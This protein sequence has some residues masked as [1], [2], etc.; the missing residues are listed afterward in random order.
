MHCTSCAV[1]VS[2]PD[3]TNSHHPGLGSR[4]QASWMRR[5][6][7]FCLPRHADFA[8]PRTHHCS[9]DTPTEEHL[10]CRCYWPRLRF[11]EGVSTFRLEIGHWRCVTC[12]WGGSP[13]K[14]YEENQVNTRRC[15]YP[16][17]G[18]AVSPSP[19]FNLIGDDISTL[20]KAAGSE[21]E[22]RN[23]ICAAANNVMNILKQRHGH[24]ESGTC[25]GK[26][27]DTRIIGRLPAFGIYGNETQR[28]MSHRQFFNSEYQF[29]HDEFANTAKPSPFAALRQKGSSINTRRDGSTADRSCTAAPQQYPKCYTAAPHHMVFPQTH[30]HGRIGRCCLRRQEDRESHGSLGGL[31]L[32]HAL[33][34]PSPE[35]RCITL[36][37][38]VGSTAGGCHVLC[39]SRCWCCLR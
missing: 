2:R 11:A 13:K 7:R 14:Q 19:V 20:S 39:C 6:T 37:L 1:R 28:S 33:H 5:N 4:G 22:M 9:L 18:T 36:D 10:G 27:E 25:R 38:Q 34:Q 31:R 12:V 23:I 21:S 24:L 35:A 15:A 3:S 17:V 16:E 26:S 30:R 29:S 8:K 32:V